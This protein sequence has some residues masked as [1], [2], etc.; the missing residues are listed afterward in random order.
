MRKLCSSF[1]ILLCCVLPAQKNDGIPL[2]CLNHVYVVV[3]S[4]TYQHLCDSKI[5]NNK[6]CDCIS[7]SFTTT[8][9]S[10]SGN[11]LL[12]KNGY[13]EIYVPKG[14]TNA[15]I[16]DIGLGFITFRVDDIWQIRNTWQKTLVD[17]IVTDT[18]FIDNNGIKQS[19]YYSIGLLNKSPVEHFSAW[20]MEYTPERLMDIGFNESELKHEITNEMIV[21]KRTNKTFTKLLDKII[22]IHL[23]L[24]KDE[25]E[26]LSK[27][28][29]NLGLHQRKSVFSNQLVEISFD[30][31]DHPAMRIKTIVFSLNKNVTEQR[32]LISDHLLLELKGSV[33]TFTFY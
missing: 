5:L 12:G 4:I 3:D 9:Q 21:K 16:G 26:Y 32:L 23:L 31:I 6:I 24:S 28:V 13:I 22:S 14:L 30:I 20:L 1:S 29:I 7:R 17:T 19:V 18:T 27:T 15:S 33:A 10:Y 25:F 8:T 2:V 11:Y